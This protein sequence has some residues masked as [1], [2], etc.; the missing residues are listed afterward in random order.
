LSQWQF[1]WKKR[2]LGTLMP[3][4]NKKQLEH[5]NNKLTKTTSKNRNGLY[6]ATVLSV[7]P[8]SLEMLSK[9]FLQGLI[10]HLLRTTILGIEFR[11]VA[12]QIGVWGRGKHIYYCGSLANHAV[13]HSGPVTHEFWTLGLL[14]F[15]GPGAWF[16]SSATCV[17]RGTVP[18]AVT[19][20][21]TITI[22]VPNKH[23]FQITNWG[24]H[25]YEQ[26]R[27]LKTS[28]WKIRKKK[29]NIWK[30]FWWYIMFGTCYSVQLS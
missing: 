1:T 23:K 27:L 30:K 4:P 24:L 5:V 17:G 21:C 12:I 20:P 29:D 13:F 10:Q 22:T 2:P 11:R 16:A 15:H 28:I 8:R 19:T 25:Q 26:L 6:L 7:K 14:D 18:S 9:C 3:A